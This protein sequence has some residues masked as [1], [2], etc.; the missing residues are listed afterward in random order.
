METN[1][2]SYEIPKKPFKER[3]KNI[4]GKRTGI[5][6]ALVILLFLLMPLILGMCSSYK[7]LI[8]NTDKKYYKAKAVYIIGDTLLCLKDSEIYTSRKRALKGEDKSFSP[9]I[10]SMKD[11]VFIELIHDPEEKPEPEEKPRAAG[12]VSGRYLG[13]YRINAENNHGFL[14]LKRSKSGRAYGSIVFPKWARGVFEK[15]KNVKVENGRIRFTRSA[16]SR[17]EM[18]RLG[19]NKPFTQKY[20]GVYKQGGYRI[21]G[22]YSIPTGNRNW[23]AVK[24][25]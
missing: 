25:K 19:I 22:T 1:Q 3:L 4:S 7:A 5:I 11:V 18:E 2:T 23:A 13:K 8:K 12:S 20:S 15:L 24:V 6:L 9:A 10:V 17:Q 14:Y 16:T 21:D